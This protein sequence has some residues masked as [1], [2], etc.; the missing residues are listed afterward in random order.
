MYTEHIPEEK[1][2]IKGKKKKA[3]KGKKK[4]VSKEKM[5]VYMGTITHFDKCVGEIREFLQAQSL[6]ENTIFI[7]MTD[8]GASVGAAIYNA[9]MRGRKGTTFDGGHRV[10]F[11]IYW[12]AGNLVGGKDIK[13]LTAHIDVLPTL[14]DLCRLNQPDNFKPDGI[15]LGPLFNGS[16][17]V[18]DDRIV[19]ESFKH[20][21]M[22]KRW[23]LLGQFRKDE[24]GVPD[25][26]YDMQ[27]DPGQKANVA[28]HHPDVVANLS[29]EI[30][31]NIKLEPKFN[32]KY[33][34]GSDKHNPIEF[35][36]DEYHDTRMGWFQKDI[37]NGKGGPSSI[38]VL[39]DKEGTYE[40]A[41]RRW[42]KDVNK[43]ISSSIKTE[44]PSNSWGGSKTVIGKALPIVKAFLKVGDFEKSSKV[45]NRMLDVKFIVQL[46]KGEY[47][48]E[49]KF[50]DKQGN[51]YLV[52]YLYVKRAWRR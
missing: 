23:R 18:F 2:A 7:F 31:D 36:P 44:V 27:A 32:H 43:P 26:L 35:T 42:P 37:I 15:S 19:V 52:Y 45:T 17:R 6:A 5:K 33:I 48:I 4:K 20:I 21:V 41:L 22:T 13:Q 40:F 49:P 46:K 12:P 9:G 47:K 25:E 3:I 50:F 34:I 10:P 38:S 16:S 30:N 14:I 24:A 28:K 1:K 11:F 29:A 8:N 39:V 51:E